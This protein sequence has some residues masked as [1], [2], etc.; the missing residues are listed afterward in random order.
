MTYLTSPAKIDFPG[1]T[2]NHI[3][4]DDT[5]WVF[6]HIKGWTGGAPLEAS[7]V[8]RAFSNGEFAQHGR[9]TGRLITIDGWV[10]CADDAAVARA[11]DTLAAL[12]ADGA[13]AQMT[14]TD[15]RLG[16]RWAKVQ[17]IGVL[18]DDWS[19]P[20]FYDFQIQLLAP[21]PYKYGATSSAQTGLF[22]I[23]SGVGM[24][25]NLFPG[26]TMNFNTA[27]G[28]V[29]GIVTLT[30][31]GTA[32]ASVRISIA[33]PTPAGGFTITD[34]ATAKRI[35]WLGEE[36]PAGSTLTLDGATS[37]VLIDGIADRSGKV[38]VEAW[39]IVPAGGSLD[40]LFSVT[41]GGS[42]AAVMTAEC[43][44]TYH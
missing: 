37:T 42:S 17:R 4:V 36:I 3:D 35:I 1:L 8:Q 9:K 11:T 21:S 16:E 33:G 10:Y 7:R 6:E 31:P 40:L 29:T 30:N 22:D 27:L 41:S 43:W 34:Q 13:L 24:E 19:R 2:L 20:N 12:L 23:P 15:D 5:E 26:G 39:P 28:V 38:L 25:F 18:E 32:D 44:A 14:V